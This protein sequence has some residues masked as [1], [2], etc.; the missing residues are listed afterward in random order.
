MGPNDL[1]TWSGT[2]EVMKPIDY[3]VPWSYLELGIRHGD[4]ITYLAPHVACPAYLH[5][6][7]DLSPGDRVLAVGELAYARGT[8]HPNGGQYCL[9]VRELYRLDP[10]GRLLDP[11]VPGPAPQG[12]PPVVSS[13]R[14]RRGAPDRHPQPWKEDACPEHP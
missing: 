4:G 9:K 12:D 5:V 7:E 3:A 2:G 8:H 6:L 1:N 14:K 10:R 11:E 13:D